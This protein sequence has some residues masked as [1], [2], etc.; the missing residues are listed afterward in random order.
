VHG[1]SPLRLSFGK[2]SPH[3]ASANQSNARPDLQRLGQQTGLDGTVKAS[4]GQI[5]DSTACVSRINQSGSFHQRA[6]FQA[7]QLCSCQFHVL[8]SKV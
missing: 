5:K 3:V 1:E 7:R 8:L 6:I 2:K 4:R